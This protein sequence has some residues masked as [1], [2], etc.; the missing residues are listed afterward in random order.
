M[1]ATHPGAARFGRSVNTKEPGGG[2]PGFSITARLPV[3]IMPV[4]AV[5]IVGSAVI[6]VRPRSIVV[7]WGIVVIP[8]AG[9]IIVRYAPAATAPAVSAPA[10]RPN[11]NPGPHPPLH[12]RAS[13]GADIIVAPTVATVARIANAFF[14]RLLPSST[15]EINADGFPG[16]PWNRGSTERNHEKRSCVSEPKDRDEVCLSSAATSQEVKA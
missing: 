16:L 1:H 5:P 6:R 14:M 11:A 10:A 3:T 2:A 12:P 7:G 13:A 9:P 15:Y 4:I 8:V